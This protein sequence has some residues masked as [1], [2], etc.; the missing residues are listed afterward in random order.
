M[1]TASRRWRARHP[2][3]QKAATYRWRERNR[4]A[5]NAYQRFWRST[6]KE[7]VKAATRRRYQKVR[8]DPERYEKHLAAGREWLRKHPE[9][10]REKS[11]R[12]RAKAPDKV[13]A[14][15][16][17][18]MRRWYATHQLEGRAR[19]RRR[20]AAD[21]EK[22]RAYGRALY[23]LYRAKYPERYA[24]MLELG[25]AWAKRNRPKLAHWAS[26]YR[27]RRAGALGSHTFQQWMSCVEFHK[28]KCVY[29][30]TSLTPKTLTKDHVLPLF[31]GGTNYVE[32]LVPA[33][34]SCNSSKRDRVNFR[35]RK[36]AEDRP[37]APS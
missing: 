20:R 11:R 16:R 19:N 34:K 15:M 12:Q 2:A 6:R 32:N 33:C 27:A 30:G 35:S 8:A 23:R 36:E 17:A 26:C 22:W 18:W 10:T 31:G 25:R 9:Y 7:L 29:C 28:W 13:R 21:P 5:W 1:R 37:L 24:R 3:K 4:Q 14:Y